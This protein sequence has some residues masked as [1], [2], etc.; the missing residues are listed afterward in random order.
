DSLRIGE[1]QH[2]SMLP[3]TERHRG[4]ELLLW[5]SA[6]APTVAG[7]G[8]G[9]CS[10]GPVVTG[11][12][13]VLRLSKPAAVGAVLKKTGERAWYRPIEGVTRVSAAGRFVFAELHRGLMCLD[14]LSGTEVWRTPEDTVLVGNA[15]FATGKVLW[16]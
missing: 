7:R 14:A 3:S 8:R 12:V 13:A 5:R 11:D 9:L 2:A 10:S 15:A 4:E 16:P 1:V 6:A